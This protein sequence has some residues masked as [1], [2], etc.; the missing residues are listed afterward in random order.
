MGGKSQLLVWNHE[1]DYAFKSL[2]IF[3]CGWVFVAVQAL[4]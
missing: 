2:F 3:G 4:F 1:D